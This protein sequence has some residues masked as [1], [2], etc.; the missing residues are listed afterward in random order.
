MK[1]VF[2]NLNLGLNFCSLGPSRPPS[3]DTITITDTVI[4]LKKLYDAQ[5]KSSVRAD[6][7]SPTQ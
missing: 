7:D 5:K 6:S 3:C 4:A 2:A 1:E